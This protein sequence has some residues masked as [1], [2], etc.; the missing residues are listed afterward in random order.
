VL[1]IHNN[2]DKKIVPACRDLV[3]K[4]KK[5]YLLIFMRIGQTF[6]ISIISKESK[7]RYCFVVLLCRKRMFVSFSVHY[8][9]SEVK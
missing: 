5:V 4:S 8:F 7:K 3:G 6:G 2:I 9:T 1:F